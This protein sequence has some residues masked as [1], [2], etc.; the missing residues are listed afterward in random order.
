MTQEQDTETVT[1]NP[2]ELFWT[3]LIL[4]NLS[5]ITYAEN[6]N[7]VLTLA[8]YVAVLFIYT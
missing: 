8:I 5:Y 1:L 4:G 6:V 2:E 7:K 3:V